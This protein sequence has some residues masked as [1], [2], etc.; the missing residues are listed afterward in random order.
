MNAVKLW[1]SRAARPELIEF[2]MVHDAGDVATRTA[3]LE[4][5]TQS[6]LGTLASKS[7][8][9]AQPHK[10]GTCVKGWNLAAEHSRGHVM[11]CISDDFVPP[12]QWDHA[13]MNLPGIGPRWASVEAV[14]RVYDG[15]VR[16]LCTLP[17]VTRRR[18][19]KMGDVLPA[20]YLS[21]FVDTELTSRALMDGVLLDAPHLLFEHQH[22]DNHKR[23]RDV[24]DEE[25]GGKHRYRQGELLFNSRRA[26]GFPIDTG[27]NAHHYRVPSPG[28]MT[29]YAA[30][31]QSDRPENLQ[32][33]PLEALYND[34][35]RTFFFIAPNEAWRGGP[36]SPAL[37]AQTVAMAE[38]VSKLEGAKAVTQTLP[39][40]G[41]RQT[42]P[43]PALMETGFCNSAL[44]TIRESGFYHVLL[45]SN[46]WA[47]G[48]AVQ[49]DRIAA[50]KNPMAIKTRD[51]STV[52]VRADARFADR[53]NTCPC[54]TRWLNEAVFAPSARRSITFADVL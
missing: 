30:F 17:I 47:P 26:Q 53:W 50:S 21:M 46:A 22:C 43:T 49:I 3:M 29:R 28:L 25:H 40:E 14:V 32:W 51:G 41:F 4:V 54:S 24:I 10:P 27:K 2:V 44:D 7:S 52:Y 15:Y 23:E 37:I 12:A 5:T 11:I 39:V 20:G 36:L 48:Q 34:G 9:H 33:E 42:A 35:I 38:R 19:D 1:S 31:V 45:V 18:Y 16:D 8:C 13:L 6:T